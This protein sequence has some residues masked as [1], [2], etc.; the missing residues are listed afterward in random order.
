MGVNTFGTALL[1]LVLSG[2][3]LF[4]AIATGGGSKSKNDLH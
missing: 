1:N 2:V 4:V 3:I